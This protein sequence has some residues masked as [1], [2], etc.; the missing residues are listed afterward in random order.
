MK[1]PKVLI[2]VKKGHEYTNQM[3]NGTMKAGLLNSANFIKEALIHDLKIP[4]YL[5]I[6]IDG[7]DIDRKIH[8]YKPT[9]CFLEA[10]WVTPTKL[11]ELALL[12]PKVDFVVRIHSK[13]PFL[14]NEGIALQWIKEYFEIGGNVSIAF[15]NRHTHKDF[16]HVGID[17]DY[18]PNIYK[19]DLEYKP[20]LVGSILDLLRDRF[21]CFPGGVIDVGCFGAIRPLKNQ[22]LQAVAAMQYADK[23]NLTLRFHI[24]GTRLEQRGEVVL[25]NIRALF[26]NTRHTLVEHS[27][28]SHIDF[29]K[30]VKKMDI[31]LQLSFTES[32]NIVTADF[33][34]SKVPVIVGKDIEWMNKYAKCDPNNVDKVVEKMEYALRHRRSIARLNIE[35][36]TNYNTDSLRVWR[37]Y[38]KSYMTTPKQKAC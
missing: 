11:R 12:H 36:L 7:N 27:W 30:L 18:L 26:N 22:L 31:G 17:N 5:E 33:V 20:S 23:H 34:A 24:N 19:V 9:H 13:I 16:R 28:M 1:S 4:A 25:K 21:N 6:C 29:L 3:P 14:A 35:S 38:F 10:I 32:F 2:L 15:N 8:K 37:N